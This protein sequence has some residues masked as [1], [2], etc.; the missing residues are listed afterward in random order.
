[1]ICIRRASLV[2][3]ASTFPKSLRDSATLSRTATPSSLCSI[4]LALNLIVMATLNP[5]SRNSLA[6]FVL[7]PKSWLSILGRNHISLSSTVCC[8]RRCSCRRFF[9][10]YLCLPMSMSL[11]TGGSASGATS[12]R[13]SPLSSAT[14]LASLRSKKPTVSPPSPIRRTFGAVMSLLTRC[15]GWEEMSELRDVKVG[16]TEF[17][18]VTSTMS[19]WR[20]NQLS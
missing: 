5:C 8:C 2:L 9:C 20:S 4:S 11:H 15:L 10:L 7:T 12:T 17:E 18:S 1:M 13:S 19:T 14:L 3:L 6:W 16:D